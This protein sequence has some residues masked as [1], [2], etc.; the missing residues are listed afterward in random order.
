MTK[1]LR[2]K[3][4]KTVKRERVRHKPGERPTRHQWVENKR[5]PAACA[6][7]PAL[8]HKTLGKRGGKITLYSVKGKSKLSTK[9]T[10]CVRKAR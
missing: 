2:R 8:K 9:K 5:G 3:T 10:K 6:Y 1:T 7:C 4:V